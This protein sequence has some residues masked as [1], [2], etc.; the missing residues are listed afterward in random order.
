MIL[1]VN[2]KVLIKS[3]VYHIKLSI[4][5]HC[6]RFPVTRIYTDENGE[7]QFGI[8]HIEMKSD[9]MCIRS[10]SIT[11]MNCRHDRQHTNLAISLHGSRYPMITQSLTL[12]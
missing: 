4:P 11:L 10:G 7:S 12:R 6:I 2:L 3:K 8:F 5:E 9:G 1:G